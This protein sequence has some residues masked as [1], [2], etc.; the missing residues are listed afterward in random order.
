MHLHQ[1]KRREV[2]TL[3]GGAAA[4]PITARAQ[5]AERVRQL[6]VLMGMQ[7]SDPHAGPR[8]AAFERRLQELGWTAGRNVRIDYQWSS[9]NSEKLR[10]QATELIA[11]APELIVAAAYEQANHAWLARMRSE[12]QFW[13]DLT[14]KL[15]ATRS[16]PEALE[17]C[18]KGA[19]ERTQ[20]AAEDGRRLTEDYQKIMQKFS[21]S[22]FTGW[23]TKGT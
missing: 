13:S 21:G 7:Q 18:Q 19:T 3:L 5:P 14:A 1:W 12:M 11:L 2:I 10:A 16:V 9:E 15:A 22:L 17:A 20:M 4:W 23:P 8:V 6:G